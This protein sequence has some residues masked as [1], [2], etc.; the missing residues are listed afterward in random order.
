VLAWSMGTRTVH[1]PGY[2]KGSENP[3]YVKYA[4]WGGKRKW[5]SGGAANVRINESRGGGLAGRMPALFPTTD[6]KR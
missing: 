3:K 6:S 1:N 4:R 5:V 2:P